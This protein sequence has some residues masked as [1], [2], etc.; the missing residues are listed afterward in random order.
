[1]TKKL[2]KVGFTSRG[3]TIFREENEVGGHR[4][5]SDEIGGG[6]CVWDTSL[7]DPETLRKCLEIEEALNKIE[8]RHFE[9]IKKYTEQA[10]GY[11]KEKAKPGGCQLH[12]LHCRY[13]DCDKKPVD[14]S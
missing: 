10:T 9:E 6:V 1:M 12:N 11:C 2:L 14:P 3:Y 5:W 7:A 13:P 8:A 4:Y